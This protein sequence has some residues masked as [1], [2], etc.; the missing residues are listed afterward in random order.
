MLLSKCSRSG[1][2]GRSHT[3]LLNGRQL[4]PGTATCSHNFVHGHG[5]RHG[6]QRV[7]MVSGAVLDAA[8]RRDV[9]CLPYLGS[10][11]KG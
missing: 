4:P 3:R 1:C 9:Q 8:S 5:G 6:R 10:N 11:L 7:P 2:R